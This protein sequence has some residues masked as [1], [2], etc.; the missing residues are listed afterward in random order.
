MQLCEGLAVGGLRGAAAA[1]GKAAREAVEA[2]GRKL[3]RGWAACLA[4]IFEVE[5][6][7]CARCGEA[8]KPV[9]AVVEDKELDRLLAYLG[10][11]TDFPKTRPARSPP[12]WCGGEDTQLDPRLEDWDGRDGPGA[13]A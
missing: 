11:E 6:L 7:R 12:P 10:V 3:G 1:L 4:R 2:A 9:A 8:M 13:D 5:A